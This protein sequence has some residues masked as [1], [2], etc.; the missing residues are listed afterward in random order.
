MNTAAGAEWSALVLCAAAC[1][2][3]LVAAD[4]LHGAGLEPEWSRKLVHVAMGLVAA[5]FPWLFRDPR[6]VLALCAAFAVLLG[7]GRG[8]RRLASVHAVGDRSAGLVWFPTAVA[9][10][11]LIAA[12]RPAHYA[13]ALVVLALADPAAAL[14]GRARGA[15]RFRVGAGWKSVEGSLAF[16]AVASATIAAGLGWSTPLAAP[17]VLAFAAAIGALLAIVEAVSPAGTDNLFVPLGTL[18]L[19]RGAGA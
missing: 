7:C 3:I 6:A 11:F 10:A 8:W 4:V 16:F 5:L 2:A 19:L 18:L 9:L 15:H 17:T 12:D 1:T 14:V 13:L